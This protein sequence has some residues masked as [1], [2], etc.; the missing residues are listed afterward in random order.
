M[1]RHSSSSFIQS[2]GVLPKLKFQPSYIAKNDTRTFQCLVALSFNKKE[3]IRSVQSGRLDPRNRLLSLETDQLVT[4]LRVDSHR[5][6]Q[7][8]CD[9]FSIFYVAFVSRATLHKACFG[10]GRSTYQV[11]AKLGDLL[12]W[13]MLVLSSKYAAF[14]LLRHIVTANVI[15]I[16][17]L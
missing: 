2:I 3:Q 15:Y 6:H 14:F 13:P 17:C 9:F 4:S 7:T 8:S 5:D 12:Y 1:A 11:C 16:C 10:S